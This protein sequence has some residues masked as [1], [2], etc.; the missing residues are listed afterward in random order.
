MKKIVLFALLTAL[1]CLAAGAGSP[2]FGAEERRDIQNV[3]LSADGKLTWD[4]YE[5]ATQYWITFEPQ[6]AFNPGGTSADLYQRALDYDFLSGTHSFTLVACDDNWQNLSYIYSGTYEFT[7]PV[8]LPAPADPHWDGRTARW[9]PVEGAESY[10]L[11]LYAGESM[12]QRYFVDETFLDFSDSI[13]LQKNSEYS[14]TVA[15]L[16]G[17][18]GA[19]SEQSAKSAVLAG[20]FEQKEIANVKIDENGILSWDAYEGATRY[21]LRLGDGAWEPNGLSADLNLLFAGSDRESGDYY[22]DLVACNDN[23]ADLSLHAAGSF[24]YEKHYL[25]VFELPDEKTFAKQAVKPG[26]KAVR[27][28]DPAEDG[29]IFSGWLLEGKPYDFDAAVT[30]NLT[31]VA[32]FTDA[33]AT[34]EPATEAPATEMPATDIPATDVPVT[35][36]PV[37]NTAEPTT[38]PADSTAEPGT[39]ADNY[40]GAPTPGSTPRTSSNKGKNA[41][42]VIIAVLAGLA[43]IAGAVFAVLYVKKK[44]K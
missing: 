5:G 26:A 4:P 22:Y 20:W 28:A 42:P 31:L 19:N 44:K 14:F 41:A 32:S 17:D 21:W 35:E 10:C 34:D 12:I 11:Y 39:T 36:V 15:A 29:K 18:S 7:A 1:L 16:A 27:P 30:T 9:E 2:A 43:V 8:G 23:W 24:S 6:A 38:V 33:P 3:Q 25:V 37:D 40:A 13:Q